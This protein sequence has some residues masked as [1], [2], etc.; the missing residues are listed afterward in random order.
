MLTQSLLNPRGT[1][2]TARSSQPTALGAWDIGTKLSISILSSG[3]LDYTD[4]TWNDQWQVLDEWKDVSEHFS[5]CF[6][7][8]FCS[9]GEAIWKT[10][11][12]LA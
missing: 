1:W 3:Y 5:F 6:Q 8:T 10:L 12:M 4:M 11:F 9:S 7:N 2:S